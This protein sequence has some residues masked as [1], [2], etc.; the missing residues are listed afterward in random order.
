[1]VDDMFPKLSDLVNR[2]YDTQCVD[3]TYNNSSS[4][5]IGDIVRWTTSV[6]YTI[7]SSDLP[8]LIS[9]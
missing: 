4:P 5:Q 9:T 8:K 6:R 1:M 7:N 3:K 2:V